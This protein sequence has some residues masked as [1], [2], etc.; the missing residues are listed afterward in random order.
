MASL[1]SGSNEWTLVPDVTNYSSVDLEFIDLTDTSTWT[2][3]DLNSAIKTLAISG[4]NYNK[5]TMNA[6]TASINNVWQGGSLCDAPRWYTP[7]YVTNSTGQNIRAKSSDTLSLTIKIERGDVIVDT[8]VS[9]V[10]FGICL[11]PTSYTLASVN[12]SGATFNS[13]QTAVPDYGVWAI[14]T[15]TAAGTGNVTGAF[16]SSILAAGIVQSTAILIRADGTLDGKAS[17]D[18]NATAMSADQDLFLM[19]GVGTKNSSVVV[20][21]EDTSFRIQYRAIKIA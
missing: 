20:E 13:T 6:M 7:L 8:W 18:T 9:S 1:V 21:D 15:A 3:L 10:V 2:K 16:V 19:L 4:S 12:G 11:D 17:R 14:N 5:V